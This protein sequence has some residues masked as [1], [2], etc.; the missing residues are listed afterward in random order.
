LVAEP[1]LYNLYAEAAVAFSAALH[2][3]YG[4]HA[5]DQR[6]VRNAALH[7]ASVREAGA[8]MHRR[9]AAF[10]QACGNPGLAKAHRER[11]AE[12]APMPPA[13]PAKDGG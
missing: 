4:R 3:A 11:A 2:K 6:Y 8:E 13:S 7:P 5:V 1:G 12:F 9:A 10:F